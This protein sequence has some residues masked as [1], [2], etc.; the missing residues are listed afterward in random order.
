[1]NQQ[2]MTLTQTLDSLRHALEEYIEATY[3]IRDPKLLAQRRAL[4]RTPGVIAQV[5]FVEAIPQYKREGDLLMRGPEATL[6]E[7]ARKALEAL[8]KASADDL[9]TPLPERVFPPY[10]HQ[11]KAIRFALGTHPEAPKERRSLVVTTGTGSGKTECFMIPLLSLL[12]QQAYEGRQSDQGKKRWAEPAVRALVLY[13]MNALVN[14]QLGRLRGWLG[15]PRITKLICDEWHVRPIRFARYTSRTPYP[16]LRRRIAGKGPDGKPLVDKYGRVLFKKRDPSRLTPSASGRHPKAV[17]TFN[18]FYVGVEADALAAYKHPDQGTPDQ[19]RNLRLIRAL[20]SLGKWPAKVNLKTWLGDG[21]WEKKGAA[22]DGSEDTFIRAVTGPRDAELYTRHEALAAPP[23]VLVTNYSMLEYMLMRP[24]ES[25]LFEATATWFEAH[26]DEKFLLVVDEAHL[27][28]GTQGAEVALLLRRLLQRLRITPERLQVIMTSASFSNGETAKAFAA[29]LVG[30]KAEDFE[31]ITGDVVDPGQAEEEGSWVGALLKVNRERFEDL[32]LTLSERAQAVRSVLEMSR[33]NLAAEPHWSSFLQEI[34]GGGPSLEEHLYTALEPAWP[35]H[36]LRAAAM[37]GQPDVTAD[38]R[39]PAGARPV[40]QV[41][42]DYKGQPLPKLMFPA[43]LSASDGDQ[44]LT[45]LLSLAST[46]RHGKDALLPSRA[47]AF[48][49]GLPGLWVCLDPAC[50]ALPLEARGG[51][52]GKLYAADPGPT[53]ECGHRV[54]PLFTCRDCGAAFARGYTSASAE[55]LEMGVPGAI[56][57]ASGGYLWSEP[58]HRIVVGDDSDE[59]QGAAPM[60]PV[61]LLLCANDSQAEHAAAAGFQALRV[62]VSGRLV[63][64]SSA[65]GSEVYVIGTPQ[66]KGEQKP[67]TQKP[68]ARKKTAEGAETRP[69]AVGP[70]QAYPCPSC[71]GA[72]GKSTVQDHI[73]KGQQPFAALIGQQLRVQRAR[74]VPGETNKERA[75]RLRFAPLEGRKV[76]AFSDSRQKAAGLAIDLNSFAA[77]DAARPM[78]LRGLQKLQSSTGEA[79]TLSEGK[80]AF[81]AGESLLS[82]RLR[83]PIGITEAGTERNLEDIRDSWLE[84]SNGGSAKQLVKWIA[85]ASAK[86]FPGSWNAI[87]YATLVGGGL[88]VDATGTVRP[89][90]HRPGALNRAT[91]LTS[92]ALAYVAPRMDL[93]PAVR[94]RV[95]DHKCPHSDTGCPSCRDRVVAR[96]LHIISVARGVN[97]RD[98]TSADWLTSEIITKVPKRLTEGLKRQLENA[99]PELALTV[100]HEGLREELSTAG[101]YLDGEKLT[102]TVPNVKSPG[103]MWALC[104]TCGTMTP[105][106]P[107]QAGACAQCGAYTA[108][109]LNLTLSEKGDLFALAEQPRVQWFAARKDLYRRPAVD[110]LLGSG[111]TLF[112]PTSAEHTAQVGDAPEG[113][114][115]S[116]AELHELLF[117]DVDVGYDHR[118]RRRTAVDVLSS[119]TTMEVGIDIGTLAGVALR[120]MP[121][122]RDNY[123]QRAGRAGRRG[124]GVATVIAYANTGTH[125]TYAYERPEAVL[126]D[127]VADPT[128]A[129]DNSRVAYRHATAS[130]IQQYMHAQLAKLPPYESPQLF[131][132]LGTLSDFLDPSSVVSLSGFETWIHAL[133]PKHLEAVA[134]WAAEHLQEPDK[135]LF[136]AELAGRAAN[137]VR[138]ACTD[139]WDRLL[140]G[141]VDGEKA[142]ERILGVTGMRLDPMLDFLWSGKATETDWMELKATIQPAQMPAGES[143]AQHRWH[144]ARALIAMRNTHGGV[145]VIGAAQNQ[146]QPQLITPTPGGFGETDLD[147]WN[148]RFADALLGSAN[149]GPSWENKNGKKVNISAGSLQGAVT[150]RSAKLGGVAV[151]LLVVSR[152]ARAEDLVYVTQGDDPRRFLLRRRLGD[153]GQ[154]H[155]WHGDGDVDA[156]VRRVGWVPPRI[157]A[158]VSTFER[159]WEKNSKR[160][161]TSTVVPVPVDQSDDHDEEDEQP[162]G[163]PEA[164]VSVEDQPDDAIGGA[165]GA[166]DRAGEPAAARR[167]VGRASDDP[168]LLRLLID[169]GVLPS[170]A[171]PTAVVAFHVLDTDTI[172]ARRPRY[173]YSAST[174]IDQALSQYA[175]GRM[176]ALDNQTWHVGALYD[177]SPGQPNRRRSY[178]DR[179]VYLHCNV[180]GHFT[181]KDNDEKCFPQDATRHP[182]DAPV[183]ARDCPVCGTSVPLRAWMRP[184]GFL[185]CKPETE[186]SVSEQVAY[187]TSAKLVMPRPESG[188]DHQTAGYAEDRVQVT[189][190]WRA[191]LQVLNEGAQRS[192][193]A[194]CT[195]CG[196]IE[197]AVTPNQSSWR[198]WNETHNFPYPVAPKDGQTPQCEGKWVTHHLTLGHNFDTDVVLLTFDL[199]KSGVALSPKDGESHDGLRSLAEALSIAASERVLKIQDGELEGGFRWPASPAGRAGLEAEVYLFDRVPGG[200]GYAD[201]VAARLTEVFA[202]A[203]EL[204]ACPKRG[205]ETSCY[206]CL[207]RYRNQ[208]HHVTLDRHLALYLLDAIEH[209]APPS[210]WCPPSHLRLIRAVALDIA[211]QLEVGGEPATVSVVDVEEPDEQEPAADPTRYLEVTRGT[212]P[213][214]VIALRRPFTPDGSVLASNSLE[215]LLAAREVDEGV[216]SVPMR[217]YL[218]RHNLPATA[219]WALDLVRPK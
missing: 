34:A 53:C 133:P 132:V 28:R 134:A 43:A 206:S 61:D 90:K 152:A 140:P 40:R 49:R 13:P 139:A 22:P 103:D 163:S 64:L 94:N 38:D 39:R 105:H 138:R 188:G 52:A 8:S 108:T 216:T 35:V 107:S 68:N 136:A 212:R 25:Y 171:F 213:P 214:A 167:E 144:V 12:A 209:G 19:H 190:R 63:T 4:L 54:F 31:S 169:A 116:P 160:Y 74:N 104:D 207:R 178:E 153:V 18:S 218:A 57:A 20:R 95:P 155:E 118:A 69:N 37:P 129:L 211:A 154:V 55:A 96:W 92:L 193:Y 201:E 177:T 145:V 186:D 185:H 33:P 41:P 97:V 113:E 78:L 60:Q 157:G 151:I 200:A 143:A 51:V 85:T 111:A 27:Y 182:Q 30:K 46:A 165:E 56:S 45:A 50:S 120:N 149:K 219:T 21:H 156:F 172:D 203:R 65:G 127:A 99:L 117:Q 122:R 82:T 217:S 123:Q 26:P 5:P 73:T 36:R 81:I 175:P 141:A 162:T 187:P 196:R 87:V 205:C 67:S 210:R 106:A 148:S 128:L 115:F 48:F 70:G 7:G 47:H 6:P 125:D 10:V 170:Y 142:A 114:A 77:R 181:P 146:K 124:D 159:W 109:D 72:G 164:K 76:L 11:M 17:K 180:C 58:G 174:G 195:R 66:P 202:A 215:K 179:E 24:L 9:G 1:M 198:R 79:P 42:H 110:A 112:V 91:S 59:T 98:L 44:A 75:E 137:A 83:V 135:G 166:S 208:L 192:G 101:G 80:A 168:D 23:D 88:R 176:V 32:N 158:L 121:P 89:A 2:S 29:D 197:S 119:T 126:A 71:S 194:Y 14:D 93:V 86:A 131:E 100:L 15:D 130:L 161:A 173:W 84:V 189:H 102:L 150:V 3:H 191:P 184:S 62:S 204:L 199:A 147:S 183:P 16:G